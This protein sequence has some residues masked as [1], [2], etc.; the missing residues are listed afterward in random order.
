MQNTL[1]SMWRKYNALFSFKCEL[2]AKG[3]SSKDLF[4]IESQLTILMELIEIESMNVLSELLKRTYYRLLRE[5]VRGIEYL[6]EIISDCEGWTLNLIENDIEAWISKDVL[7]LTTKNKILAFSKVSRN[8]LGN[9]YI[10]G[11]WQ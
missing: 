3:Y 2:N 6:P 1:S 8:S 9:C 5:I 7:I 4:S 11:K 10:D